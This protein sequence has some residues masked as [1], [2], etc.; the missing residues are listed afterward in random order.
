MSVRLN[1]IAK[2]NRH[3]AFVLFTVNLLFLLDLKITQY[4]LVRSN[5]CF[6]VTID[7]GSRT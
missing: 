4:V 7:C 6:V 2:E 1:R 5:V 3:L